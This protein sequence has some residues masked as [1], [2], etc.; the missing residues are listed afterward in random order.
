[1]DECPGKVVQCVFRFAPGVPPESVPGLWW[2][3]G[4]APTGWVGG[5][6][7]LGGTLG[8]GG[9]VYLEKAARVRRVGDGGALWKP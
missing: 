3:S 9:R 5:R 1:M 4:R 7:G 8:G 6:S 2:S